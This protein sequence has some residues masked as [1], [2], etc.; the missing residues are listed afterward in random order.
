[1][2]DAARRQRAV[3][4]LVLALLDEEE[5]GF[6]LPAVPDVE[7]RV[8]RQLV[9]CGRALIALQTDGRDDRARRDQGALRASL[10]VRGVIDLAHAA[11]REVLA[12]DDQSV[13]LGRDVLQRR[14]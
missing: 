13:D 11:G 14:R 2:R 3:G 9:W 6:A 10:V 12:V 5:D 4:A 1:R 7:Q 8:A